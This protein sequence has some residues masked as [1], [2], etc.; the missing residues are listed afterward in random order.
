MYEMGFQ[1]PDPATIKSDDWEHLITLKT[2][3]ARKKYY[4]FLFIKAEAGKKQRAIKE[5]EKADRESRLK[6]KQFNPHIYY[7]LGGNALFMR[8]RKPTMQKW[9]NRK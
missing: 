3:S 2:P 6:E 7:G 9:K 4:R 1:A 5:A 8:I